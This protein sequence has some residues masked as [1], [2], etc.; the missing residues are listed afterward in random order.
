[1]VEGINGDMYSE[2][3]AF[4]DDNDY[5]Q[6]YWRKRRKKFHRDPLFYH[7]KLFEEDEERRVVHETRKAILFEV[8]DGKFWVPKKL[9]RYK[10]TL[11][12]VSFRR[13]YLI[14]DDEIPA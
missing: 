12:H 14:E 1:M 6:S 9:L 11:V 8:P 5:E 7:K 3:M 10:N 4:S 2:E 13:E